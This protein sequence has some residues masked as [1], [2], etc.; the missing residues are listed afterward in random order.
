VFEPLSLK[1]LGLPCYDNLTR[2]YAIS[3]SKMIF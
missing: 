3:K 2:C 1:F